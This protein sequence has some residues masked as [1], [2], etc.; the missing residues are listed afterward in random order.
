M[1]SCA[2]EYASTTMRKCD[3]NRC[4]GVAWFAGPWGGCSKP[5]GEGIKTRTV[6][7]MSNNQTQ[8]DT[9][10]PAAEMPPRTATCNSSPCHTASWK[11]VSE[12]NCTRACGGSRRQIVQCVDEDGKV[13]EGSEAT[14]SCPG[15]APAE[16]VACAPCRFCDDENQN[17]V[18]LGSTPKIISRRILLTMINQGG[19]TFGQSHLVTFTCA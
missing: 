19:S 12:G 16:W 9:N 2:A 15:Q 11:V 8:F 4:T 3:L 7:C 14:T 13:L 18:R 6:R 10:C 1:H 17:L 5:C